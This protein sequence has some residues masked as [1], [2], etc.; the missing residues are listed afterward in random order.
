[1][2]KPASYWD[3]PSW[4]F[5]N[6]LGETYRFR[7]SKNGVVHTIKFVG[8]SKAKKYKKFRK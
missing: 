2:R 7:K 4:T 1:M 3:G 8:Y 5:T 6:P